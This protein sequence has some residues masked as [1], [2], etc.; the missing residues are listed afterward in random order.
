MKQE[1]EKLKQKI[2][3]LEEKKKN[4]G[5]P[6]K[7]QDTITKHDV[8]ESIRERDEIKT[9]YDQKRKELEKEL[10]ERKKA[11]DQRRDDLRTVQIKYKEVDQK[12]RIIEF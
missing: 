1:N 2:E 12:S 9:S 8:A 10:K 11:L 5:E 4:S 6:G 3:D 7:P